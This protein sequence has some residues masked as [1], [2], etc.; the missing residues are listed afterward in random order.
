MFRLLE[1]IENRSVKRTV[2]VQTANNRASCSKRGVVFLSSLSRG[3]LEPG[4]RRVF[5]NATRLLL[6]STGFLFEFFGRRFLSP[7]GRGG[8]EGGPPRTL[9]QKLRSCGCFAKFQPRIFAAPLQ[10]VKGELVSWFRH[11]SSTKCPSGREEDL[12]FIPFDFP[13]AALR[14]SRFSSRRNFISFRSGERSKNSRRRLFFVRVDET[15]VETRGRTRELALV[16]GS[17]WNL[18]KNKIL[19]RAEMS[20]CVESE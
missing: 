8:G 17:L 2:D 19:W 4:P 20:G 12:D 10:L 6:R 14:H 7:D 13:I 11:V 9:S 18:F 1:F 3:S 16:A 5:R 15:E